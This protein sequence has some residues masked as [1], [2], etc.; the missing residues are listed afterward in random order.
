MAAVAG[1][2]SLT[3][4]QALKYAYKIPV[5]IFKH[6]HDVL[7]EM[8]FGA[9][10]SYNAQNIE[11]LQSYI[12]AHER[13]LLAY[14]YYCNPIL[15]FNYAYDSIKND[16]DVLDFISKTRYLYNSYQIIKQLKA[17]GKET[18]QLIEF[19]N[20]VI[21]LSP[22]SFIK[23]ILELIYKDPLKY[24][25]EWTQQFYNYLTQADYNIMDF[26][27]NVISNFDKSD[28]P[29]IDV[30][31]KPSL[32]Y[33]INPLT[34]FQFATW[35]SHIK[36]HYTYKKVINFVKQ[37]KITSDF[38]TKL[39][40]RLYFD[41]QKIAWKRVNSDGEAVFIIPKDEFNKY[42]PKSIM[43]DI[44]GLKSYWRRQPAEHIKVYVHDT[45][46]W[47]SIQEPEWAKWESLPDN[48]NRVSIEDM[49][50]QANPDYDYDDVI[51]EYRIENNAIHFRIYD[52]E[53]GYTNS[54]YYGDELIFTVQPT[55][56]PNIKLRYD[57][58]HDLYTGKLIWLYY[59]AY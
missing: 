10:I 8:S 48:W 40:A 30:L 34:H 51:I 54:V 36:L 45:G 50:G 6:F 19:I 42:N 11:Y 41:K 14:T 44:M 9:W 2:A 4:E 7:G 26:F 24:Y 56:D 55:T 53:H 31:L 22:F 21:D 49:K 38:Y 18:E 43:I 39:Q 28:P 13:A 23:V 16:K 15:L 47:I 29:V 33:K 58:L 52:G 20:T 35:I 25:D 1:I 46:V 17:L 57:A 12:D 59:K 3:L 5:K 32:I 37:P 27:N